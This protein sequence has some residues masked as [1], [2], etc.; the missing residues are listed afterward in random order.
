MIGL[1]ACTQG[2]LESVESVRYDH[3]L[4]DVDVRGGVRT[5]VEDVHLWHWQA[6]APT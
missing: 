6:A 1:D 2:L 3:E 5:P 4:L